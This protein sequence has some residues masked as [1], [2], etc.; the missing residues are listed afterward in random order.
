MVDT[1]PLSDWVLIVAIIIPSSIASILLYVKRGA[2]R[3]GQV[4]ATA[5]GKTTLNS[6]LLN[7]AIT[8]LENAKK[9]LAILNSSIHGQS[10]DITRLQE[11]IKYIQERIDQLS[12]DMKEL[13]DSGR[14]DRRDAIQDRKE[15]RAYRKR[16]SSRE[17]E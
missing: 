7:N 5:E 2:F 13:L 10:I 17:E 15:T 11:R 16:R 3:S 1:G 6:T 12:L 14:E 8:E 9:E 4:E